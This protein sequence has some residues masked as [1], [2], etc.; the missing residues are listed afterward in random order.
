MCAIHCTLIATGFLSTYLLFTYIVFGGLDFEGWGIHKGE[1]NNNPTR[2]RHGHGTTTFLTG[3]Q[4]RNH[5][6]CMH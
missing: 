5:K 3:N 6:T 2:S 4:D 1:A